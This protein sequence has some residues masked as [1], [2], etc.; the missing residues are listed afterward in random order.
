MPHRLKI[1]WSISILIIGSLGAYFYYDRYM[2]GNIM[3]T[4]LSSDAHYAITTDDR[5]YA[6]LWDLQKNTKKILSRDADAYSAYWIKNTSYYMWQNWKTKVIYVTDVNSGQDI[7]TFQPGFIVF[8][9]VMSTDLKYHVASDKDWNIWVGK[10]HNLTQ[11]SA[12]YDGTGGFFNKLINFTLLDNDKVLTSGLTSAGADDPKYRTGV[13]LWNLN[14]LKPI[15]DYIGNEVQTFATISPD[16][17]Y[18]VAGDANGGNLFVWDQVTGKQIYEAADLFFG[19]L[20][21]NNSE[22]IKKWTW[23]NSK[24]ISMPDEFHEDHAGGT[25]ES[26]KFIDNDHYL[27]FYMY[28]H[29]AVL[30][31]VESPWPIKYLDLGKSPM[32]ALNY[33]ERDQSMDTSPATHTLVMA[34][35]HHGGILVYQYNPQDQTLTKVWNGN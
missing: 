19:I 26:V 23:D 24:L 35:E 30:F 7:D 22:D 1:I 8:G 34:K 12:H 25:A 4:S 2:G 13:F 15:H 10:E 11:M 20:N 5:D 29:Y 32:P 18:V 33:F 28:S 31:S 9:Q 27:V 6:I 16:G 17:K 21:R 3:I 14:T